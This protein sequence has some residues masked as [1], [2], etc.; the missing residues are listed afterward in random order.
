MEVRVQVRA[1]SW[2]Q[3]GERMR[4]RLCAPE[5]VP[6][7]VPTLLALCQ[8]PWDE[9]HAAR[10]ALKRAFCDLCA[11]YANCALLLPFELEHYRPRREPGRDFSGRDRPVQVV[12]LRETPTWYETSAASW[13][14]K[15]LRNLGRY[16]GA[17]A[18]A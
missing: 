12:A 14:I 2:V 9:C 11:K 17:C 3:V 16:D 6:G 18:G 13:S 5:G 7:V 4:V 10:V 1:R 15:A 8:H